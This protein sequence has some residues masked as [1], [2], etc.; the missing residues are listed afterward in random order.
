LFFVCT[1][2]LFKIELSASTSVDWPP[3]PA[4]YLPAE[5]CGGENGAMLVLPT[6]WLPPLWCLPGCAYWLL[7]FMVDCVW[8]VR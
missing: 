1:L 7:A 2:M 8:Y 6:K 4:S 5:R 3:P